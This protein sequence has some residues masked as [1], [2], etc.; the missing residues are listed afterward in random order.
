LISAISLAQSGR[1]QK[2]TQ[3]APRPTPKPNMPATGVLGVPEGGK[4]TAHEPDGAISRAGLLN[5][6]VDLAR[7]NR[8]D[9]RQVE[10]EHSMVVLG[11]DLGRVDDVAHLEYALEIADSVFLKQVR[12]LLSR[13]RR[14]ASMNRQR[15]VLEMDIDRVWLHARQISVDQELVRF[16]DDVDH[17]P[18][19][20]PRTIPFRFGSLAGL[21]RGMDRGFR[22]HICF[23][24][25]IVLFFVR[26][27]NARMKRF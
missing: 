23:S 10:H 5:L 3:P 16:L 1:G 18:K 14:D 7:T 25:I 12:R 24:S 11:R 21:F 2:P 9:L 27:T 20:E 19:S 4:L 26:E 6:H 13:P 8:F 15:P 17:R 22:S